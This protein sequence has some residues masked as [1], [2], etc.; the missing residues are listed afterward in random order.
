MEEPMLP[1]STSPSSRDEARVIGATDPFQPDT[2][3]SAYMSI[4]ESLLTT[5]FA[6]EI[7][8]QQDL[9]FCCISEALFLREAAWVVLNSGFR[10]SIVRR[11]FPRVSEAFLDWVSASEITKE[12]RTCRKSALKAFTNQRKVDAIIAIAHRVTSEGFGTFKERIAHGG[13]AF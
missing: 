8:W 7:D 11:V 6:R 12:A 13:I 3:A 10:E 2:L 4:K 1:R 9:S 5:G